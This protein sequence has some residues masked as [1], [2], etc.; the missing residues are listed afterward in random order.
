LLKEEEIDVTFFADRMIFA[1]TNGA[2]E[3]LYELLT[4]HVIFGLIIAPSGAMLDIA[5]ENGVT[6]NG[7]TT[8]EAFE[9]N[10]SGVTYATPPVRKPPSFDFNSLLDPSQKVE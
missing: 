9:V 6:F 10:S 7:I 2:F 1:P 3:G 8:S 4:Y 5:T